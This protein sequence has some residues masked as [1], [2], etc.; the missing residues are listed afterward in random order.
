MLAP[1]QV[2][3]LVALLRKLRDEGRTILFISHKLDEVLAVADEI[4][5]IRNGRVIGTMPREEA[6]KARLAEMMIGEILARPDS[7]AK[8]RRKAYPGSQKPYGPEQ[9]RPHRPRDL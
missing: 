5:V 4:T 9:S 8:R 3:E 7:T 1:A 2:K 6:T